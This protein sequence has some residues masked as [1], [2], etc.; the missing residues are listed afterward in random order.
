MGAREIRTL[1]IMG[2]LA[3]LL[4]TLAVL[5]PAALQTPGKARSVTDMD[6]DAIQGVRIIRTDDTL[7]V[8]R[9][10]N[11]DW[12]LADDP[13]FDLDR[14]RA[15]ALVN[16]CRYLSVRE[17]IENM[18]PLSNYGLD[19]PSY[20]VEITL[21]TSSKRIFDVGFRTVDQQGRF[22]LERGSGKVFVIR[23]FAD[24]IFTLSREQFFNRIPRRIDWEHVLQIS[25]DANRLYDVILSRKDDSEP[26]RIVSPIAGYANHDAL[27]DLSD[28]MIRFK[29]D[30]VEAFIQTPS[31]FSRYGLDAPSLTMTASDGVNTF[32]IQLG[33]RTDGGE[34]YGMRAEAPGVVFKIAYQSVEWFFR[35]TDMSYISSYLFYG[36]DSYGR[37]YEDIEVVYRKDEHSRI[38][39]VKPEGESFTFTMDGR[40]FPETRAQEIVTRLAGMRIAGKAG[41]PLPTGGEEF[42]SVEARLSG[43][44]VT[45][46][47][48]F[49]YDLLHYAADQG[50][51]SFYLVRKADLD[52]F[53]ALFIPEA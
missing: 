34:I 49:E 14:E 18:E 10:Q 47:T 16:N 29:F 4:I 52:A 48:F 9:T 37:K 43:L 22:A 35:Q 36:N 6:Y 40:P 23:D 30:D 51:G 24:R 33:D 32:G 19:T 31:E 2:L 21:S 41:D 26:M 11:G 53:T 50:F 13:S 39:N 5:L 46:C 42:F 17:T 45:R 28:R 25:I 12:R 3:A 8:I 15:V 44:L 20:S 1:W 38:L 7:A 27:R